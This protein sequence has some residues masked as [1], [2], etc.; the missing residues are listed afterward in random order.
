MDN[1]NLT[2]EGD[3]W[4]CS[5]GLRWDTDEDDPHPKTAEE[6]IAKIKCEMKKGSPCES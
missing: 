5:C 6:H 1:H 4:V 2:R 3:E